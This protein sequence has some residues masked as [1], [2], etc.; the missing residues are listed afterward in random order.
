MKRFILPDAVREVRYRTA[1]RTCIWQSM[2]FNTSWRRVPPSSSPWSC[3]ALGSADGL[4]GGAMLLSRDV[5]SFWARRL[6]GDVVV[7]D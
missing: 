1:Q 5:Q 6:V 2:W 3:T 4:E 7:V